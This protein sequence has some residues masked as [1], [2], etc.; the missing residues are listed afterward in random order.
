MASRPRVQYP[1]AIYH[2]TVK[3]LAGLWPLDRDSAR[4]RCLR[5]IDEALRDHPME[6]HAYCLMTNH[7]HLLLRTPG[8]GLP[9]AMQQ[10]NG[11][12]ALDY[13]RRMRRRG[14]VLE[15]PYGAVLIEQQAHLL[16]VA[17]YV[18]L[19]PVRA[20]MCA[21]AEDWLLSSC[22]ATAGL[23]RRPRFLTT[24]WLLGQ[25]HGPNGYRRFVA[26][27]SPAATLDGLL[28]AA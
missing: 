21:A 11:A 9:E 28:L 1:G 23:A 22:R 24:D 16:E 12:F 18:V 14:R 26:E 25:L 5:R 7:F 2:V 27:G 20:D 19:S 4:E 8:C 17:R 13:N 15:S 10:L 6:C 3:A